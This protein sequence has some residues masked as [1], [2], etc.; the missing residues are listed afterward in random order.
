MKNISLLNII[1]MSLFL[2]GM[3]E[4]TYCATTEYSL[5]KSGDKWRYS[6]SYKS[7]WAKKNFND[8]KWKK[9]ETPFDDQS[10]SGNCNFGGYGTDWP[11]FSTKYLRKN[12]ELSKNGDVEI[13]IAIDNDIDI[14]F[15]GS[16][17]DSIKSENCARR[18]QYKIIIPSVKKGKHTIA[19]KITDRGTENGF[20]LSAKLIT[21]TYNGIVYTRQNGTK[22]SGS[23]DYW[24][25]W[26]ERHKQVWFKVDK[27][28]FDKK[29]ASFLYK[30]GA[31]WSGETTAGWGNGPDGTNLYLYIQTRWSYWN[32]SACSHPEWFSVSPGVK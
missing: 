29:L 4:K 24:D 6:D 17:I 13:Y 12:I 26:T 32:S 1:M 22:P 25:Y 30:G 16:R 23:C 11:L 18:W 19:V 27:S 8:S 9:G 2:L 7:G 5:V 21:Y 3:T 20:D 15:D 14:Y 28:K 31:I 10:V